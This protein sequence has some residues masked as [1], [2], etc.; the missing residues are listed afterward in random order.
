MEFKEIAN[1]LGIETYP[2]KFEEIYN[3]LKDE[4]TNFCDVE[5]IEK[6]DKEYS[7]LA[8]Y[9]EVVIKGAKE[10][11]ENKELYLYG[12]VICEYKKVSTTFETRHVPLP[13]LDGSV[14]RD[15]FGVLV[16]FAFLP[17]SVLYYRN[18]GFSEEE[19]KKFY[20]GLKGCIR[21]CSESVG[22][23]CL[24]MSRFNWTLI[25]IFGEMF[26]YDAFNYQFREFYGGAIVLK[27]KTTEEFAIMMIENK[28][29]RN[30]RILG[31]AGAMDEED[32]FEADFKETDEA[33]IGRLVVK[34]IVSSDIS[35]LKKSEWECVLSPGD[36]VMAVHIPA[37]TNLAHEEFIRSFKG[38][39]EFA[40]KKFP[41]RDPKFLVCFSW[42]MD[43][44]LA[45]IMDPKSKIVGFN[46]AFM[47][48]PLES[49]GREFRHWVFPEG[50]MDNKKLPED[51]SL[52]RR[53]KALTLAGGYIYYTA[54]VCT[55]VLKPT[56]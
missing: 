37:G 50:G 3:N 35:E 14:A 15:V 16:I 4:K 10:V 7:I 30:G 33:F 26:N 39:F 48:Y 36:E 56:E 46:N 51:T 2:E 28:F 11:L 32:S 41:E 27:N 29:H 38:S 49:S 20:A 52:Q 45:E 22:R 21:K 8:D 13:V 5:E 54:G 55:E 12:R 25:Y 18:H 43:P 47:K 40:K 34:G 6:Y 17:E 42:L 1:A 53:L 23:P 44:T 24:S 31:S 19:I 9:S